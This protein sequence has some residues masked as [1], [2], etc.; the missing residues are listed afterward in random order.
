MGQ[1]RSAI[2]KHYFKCLNWS[3]RVCPSLMSSA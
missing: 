1:Q 2:A 3:L